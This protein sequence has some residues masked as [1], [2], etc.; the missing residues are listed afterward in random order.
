MQSATASGSLIG[1]FNYKPFD[2]KVDWSM[3]VKAAPCYMTV[4]CYSL[5]P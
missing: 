3:A 2:A 1:V 5:I 4:C